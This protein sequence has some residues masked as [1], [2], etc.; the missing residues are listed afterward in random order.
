LETAIRKRFS[1][2]E[3]SSGIWLQKFPYASRGALFMLMCY[4][5]TNKLPDYSRTIGIRLKK[6][7][8]LYVNRKAC[9]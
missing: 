2:T 3:A 9:V 8:S 6:I 7:V 5:K 1:V 4:V